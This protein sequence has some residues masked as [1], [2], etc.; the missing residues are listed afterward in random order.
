MNVASLTQSEIKDI[1][2]GMEV[3]PPSLQKQQMQEID[4][5]VKEASQ[6]SAQT[7]RTTDVHGKQIVTTAYSPY[8]QQKFTSR[9]DWRVRAISASNLHLRTNHI[10]VNSD[11]L[12]ETGYT[13]VL[14]K[15]VLKKF[16][17]SADLR[18]QVGG[19]LY[20]VSPPENPQVKE[21]RCI[22]MVPQLGT[23]Q[24]VSF[25]NTLPE[26]DYLLDMEPLGWIH[27]QPQETNQL[28]PFDATTQARILGEHESWDAEAAVVITVSFT[29]G[30]CSLTAYRLTAEGKRNL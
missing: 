28:S 21:V 4:K 23:H 17:G 14:P 24:A 2:L 13:Y 27:T 29:T 25:P 18:V 20:G 7:V 5:T 8:E 19:F 9:T 10:F 22:A 1:I 30:S 3:T 11:D 6:I 16:I 26:H 12:Q 15:N